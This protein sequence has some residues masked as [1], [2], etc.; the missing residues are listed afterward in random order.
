MDVPRETV[1]SVASRGERFVLFSHYVVQCQDGSCKK[2]V[3]GKR[4]GVDA[5]GRQ[6][7]MTREAQARSSL[8]I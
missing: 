8:Y 1:A 4:C 5:D 2:V 3:P 6:A 7:I